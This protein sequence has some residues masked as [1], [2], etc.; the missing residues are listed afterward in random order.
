MKFISI[1]FL[2]TIGLAFPG[3]AYA[4]AGHQEQAAEKVATKSCCQSSTQGSEEAPGPCSRG[5]GAECNC[6]CCLSIAVIPEFETL[7]VPAPLRHFAYFFLYIPP[8][9]SYSGEIWDP[10]RYWS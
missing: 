6:A 8:S 5:C 1:L 9:S 4:C 2:L 7:E 3:T 10:P